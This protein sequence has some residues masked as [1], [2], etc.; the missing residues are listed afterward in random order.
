MTKTTALYGGSFNPSTTAHRVIGTRLLE[1]FPV[2]K[3]WYLVSPQN[4]FKPFAGMAPF[5]ERVAMARLNLAGQDRL[6]VQPIEAEYARSKPNGF[7]ETAETLHL[8]RRD[9]PDMRFVWVMGADNFIHFHRWGAGV[10]TL[11]AHHP[12]IVIPRTGYT[13]QALKSPMASRL[14]RLSHASEIATSTGWH[15]MDIED[16]NINATLCRST[17]E[18]GSAPS[19]MRPGVAHYALDRRIYTPLPAP[20]DG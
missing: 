4:P 19:C 2:D 5:D 16:N 11:C 6:I 8:L 1:Q 12:V 9:F 13:E 15:L 20:G 10:D 3:V 7:I 18:M 17:L 14:P